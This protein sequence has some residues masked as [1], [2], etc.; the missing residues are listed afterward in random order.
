MRGLSPIRD[1]YLIVVAADG[2][3]ISIELLRRP[4]SEPRAVETARDHL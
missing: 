2:L 4:F 3:P 1:A